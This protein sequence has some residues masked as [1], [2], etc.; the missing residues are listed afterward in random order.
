MPALLLLVHLGIQPEGFEEGVAKPDV[1]NPSFVELDKKQKVVEFRTELSLSEDAP[2]EQAHSKAEFRQQPG[3]Q[4][5]EF[6]A[7]ASA[8][9]PHDLFMECL[10]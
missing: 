4:A 8:P 7:K 9:P 5:I 10:H 2:G 3:E 6:I 1:G